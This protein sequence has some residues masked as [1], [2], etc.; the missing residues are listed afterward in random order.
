MFF[1]AVVVV[2]V[3]CNVLAIQSYQITSHLPNLVCF[4]LLLHP[5]FFPVKVLAVALSYI[6]RQYIRYKNQIDTD[7]TNE[8]ERETKKKQA[9]YGLKRKIKSLILFKNQI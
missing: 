5:Y 4:I 9:K 2:V 8:N 6:F 7:Q 3:I 1:F